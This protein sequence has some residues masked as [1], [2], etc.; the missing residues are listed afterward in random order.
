ML[1][2]ALPAGGA[3]SIVSTDER[4]E[5]IDSAVGFVVKGA[6]AVAMVGG[7]GVVATSGT[8]GDTGGK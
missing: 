4:V 7:I 3:V 8:G 1:P 6:A 5:L 2:A